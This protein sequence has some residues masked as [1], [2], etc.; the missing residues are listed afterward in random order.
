MAASNTP[1][2]TPLSFVK[3]NCILS[4]SASCPMFKLGV[5]SLTAFFCT[6]TV[7]CSISSNC[8]NVPPFWKK[9]ATSAF[10]RLWS[11]TITFIEFADSFSAEIIS[12]VSFSPGLSLSCKITMSVPLKNGANF[13]PLYLKSF[14]LPTVATFFTPKEWHTSTHFSPSGMYTLSPAW[15]CRKSPYMTMQDWY[16]PCLNFRIYPSFS[17]PCDICFSFLPPSEI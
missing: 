2:A 11:G 15:Y 13:F 14:E 6:G 17:T 3:W 5:S 12:L 16:S 10:S 8:C 7:F 1:T 9:S 4:G